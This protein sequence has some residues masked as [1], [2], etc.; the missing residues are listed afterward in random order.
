MNNT[1]KDSKI[2]RRVVL[3]ANDWPGL[4]VARYLVSQK[5][6]IVRLYL[7][8]ENIRKLGPEIVEASNCDKDKIFEAKEVKDEKHVKGLKELKADYIITVYWSH[9]LKK[10][11]IECA[12]EGTVN[13]HPALLPINRGWYPNVHSILDGSP[14]GVTLHTIDESADT[15]LVWA[16]KE[17][18]LTEYDTAFTIHQRCQRQMVELFK[19]VWPKIKAGEIQPVPQDNSKAVYHEKSEVD[20]FDNISPEFVMK[21]EDFIKLLRARSFGNRGFAYYEKG[22]QR[23]YLNLRLSKDTFFE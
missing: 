10:D 12:V 18:A 1:S 3:M 21:V 19:E 16:Q 23:V 7:H 4:K 22:G 17:M 11:V 9:L 2:I 5:D 14:I 6:E 13:F 8:A 15:G 20:S